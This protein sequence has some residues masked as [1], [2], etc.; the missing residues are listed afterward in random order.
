MSDFCSE[1]ADF[2]VLLN[3][4]MAWEVVDN[5]VVY[6][7]NMND[8]EIRKS[9]V[10]DVLMV[11]MWEKYF[12]KKAHFTPQMLYRN[13]T[14]TRLKSRVCT[15]MANAEVHKLM[16]ISSEG[17]SIRIKDDPAILQAAMD[18]CGVYYTGFEMSKECIVVNQE[19]LQH[20]ADAAGGI[21]ELAQSV[22]MDLNATTKNPG[23]M[24]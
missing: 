10:Q 18:Y 9:L 21:D 3:T 4:D 14:S 13:I 15:Q 16:T 6:V 23:T 20:A 2:N 1:Y 8:R 5:E 19:N 12:N 17:D 24:Q 7:A 11:T 22:L